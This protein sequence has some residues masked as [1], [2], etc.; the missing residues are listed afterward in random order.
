MAL[1]LLRPHDGRAA[2]V[3]LGSQVSAMEWGMGESA[4]AF[5]LL[6]PL[7]CLLGCPL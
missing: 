4:T 1:T 5:S 3:H 7:G 2:E 6:P